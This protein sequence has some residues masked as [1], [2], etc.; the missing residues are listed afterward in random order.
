MKKQITCGDFEDIHIIT[1]GSATYEALPLLYWHNPLPYSFTYKVLS[2][3][4]IFCISTLYISR[5]GEI[6]EMNNQQ[7]E[8]TGR[9]VTPN[10]PDYNS[11]REEFN[12]FFNK[13]PLIIV[14]L[15][16]RRM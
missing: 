5:Q 8:L 7:I 1:K 11:A 6:A 14:L 13:F 10:S 3:L 2:V 15:K 9:I 12:T 16:I 4:F